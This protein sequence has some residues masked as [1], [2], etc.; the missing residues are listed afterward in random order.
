MT[1]R[2][3]DMLAGYDAPDAVRAI[4]EFGCQVPGFEYG[5]YGGDAAGRS[6]YRSDVRRTTEGLDLMRAAVTACRYAGVTDAD[7]CEATRGDRLTVEL[8]LE[9]KTAR[10]RVDYCAGQYWCTE[11]RGACARV[12][13]WAARYAVKR[14]AAAGAT[15]VAVTP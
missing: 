3:A 9:G 2:A 8:V 6:G 13:D 12:L 14:R 1:K 15:A 7:V 4:V 10:W 5:N 11:Y